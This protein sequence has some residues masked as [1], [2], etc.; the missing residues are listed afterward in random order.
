MAYAGA[1]A[2]REL[3]GGAFDSVDDEAL[4]DYLAYA[5]EEIDVRLSPHF[6]ELPFDPVPALVERICLYRAAAEVLVVYY[7]RAGAGTDD[8]R[9]GSFR[10]DY[11]TLMDMLLRDPALL[12]VELGPR[13]GAPA[14]F[15]DD[16]DQP[17]L[18][19]F[20]RLPREEA[21]PW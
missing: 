11:E 18:S 15:H 9:A 7:G 8:G 12:G 14:A 3:L 16:P 1:I 2:L 13:R 4:G 5:S 19:R 10:D 6:A 21:P 20:E 17:A